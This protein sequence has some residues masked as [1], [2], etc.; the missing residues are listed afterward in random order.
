[1]MINE[2]NLAARKQRNA[3]K[4]QILRLLPEIDGGP[5]PLTRKFTT[6]T[7]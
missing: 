6:F 1:M 2:P 5:W 4:G 7:R 3:P